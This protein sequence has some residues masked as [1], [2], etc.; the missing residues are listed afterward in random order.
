MPKTYRTSQP[1]INKLFSGN[2]PGV[3]VTLIT[4]DPKSGKTTLAVDIVRE[5][6]QEPGSEVLVLTDEQPRWRRDISLPNMFLQA[7]ADPDDYLALSL[8]VV[9]GSVPVNAP[10]IRFAR[11]GPVLLTTNSSAVQ[12]AFVQTSGL[13]L[14]VDRLDDGFS[15]LTVVKSRDTVGGSVRYKV[16]PLL[17][18]VAPDYEPPAAKSAWDR[19]LGD[20]DL[21]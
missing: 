5:T 11:M 4:G 13:V 6:L 15:R 21:V 10:I 9:D 3:G 7:S 18:I 12:M 20:E 2:L 17:G 8:I 1:G 14:R 16:D 19:L